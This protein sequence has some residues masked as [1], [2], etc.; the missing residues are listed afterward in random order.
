MWEYAFFSYIMR[1]VCASITHAYCADVERAQT[2][3]YGNVKQNITKKIRKIFFN[4]N[5]SYLIDNLIYETEKLNI[6]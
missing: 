3:L 5:T 6:C 1:P 4:D 2:V